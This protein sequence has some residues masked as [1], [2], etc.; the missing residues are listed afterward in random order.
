MGLMKKIKRYIFGKKEEPPKKK[1]KKI[2]KEQPQ[3]KITKEKDI[4]E[5]KPMSGRAFLEQ[6]NI[7]PTKKKKRNRSQIKKTTTP[8]KKKENTK[9]DLAC[10][11]KNAE[12][13]AI[14]AKKGKMKF[15]NNTFWGSIRGADIPRYLAKE[16]R[17]VGIKEIEV[18]RAKLK[19]TISPRAQI[20]LQEIQKSLE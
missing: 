5:I 20:Q 16:L 3:P 14:L 19:I 11:R 6:L 13:F 8:Q 2:K 18:N 15:H 9:I 10:L 4:I 1:V 17:K 12:I 7:Q